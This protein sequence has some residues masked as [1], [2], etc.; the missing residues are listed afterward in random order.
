MRIKKIS[1][2]QQQIL[3]WWNDTSPYHDYNA[4]ICDGAVRSGKTLFM[5][6]SF[7]FWA[8]S[9]YTG[10]QFGICGKTINSLRRNVISVILPILRQFGFLCEERVSRG[11]LTI[12][13]GGRRNTFY[14]FG[15]RDEG[16]ASL[17]QGVTF[18]G[19]MLDEVA[20]MPRSFVEQACARCSIE[21]SKIWFNCNPDSPEHWFYKEWILKSEE[22]KTYHL[23]L[24]MADNPAL[25]EKIRARYETMY[26][27][28]FY[29]RFILGQW[30]VAEGRVYD[31]FDN[32]FVRSVPDERFESWYISCDY[33]TVNPASFGLWGLLNGVWY[34]INEFYFDSRK[35]GF[36][37]TDEE[38]GVK[39][40]ELAGDRKI[41]AVIV[42][43][44]AASFIEV[45]IRK[46]FSVIRAKNDVLAG[47]R[48]TSDLLK[49]GEIVI[50]DTCAD[51]IRE[52]SLYAWDDKARCDAVIK[53]NDHAMDEIRY[54]AYTIVRREDDSFTA[55]YVER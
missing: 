24:T 40:T 14:Y 22:R 25:S 21:G 47:I 3:T 12:S 9:R 6:L 28:V 15:G 35:C 29:K 2:K 4:I 23:H 44:S 53:Q 50:C 39:V 48:I 19:A 33:G 42:D 54:F 5:G 41:N 46:G 38:Y 20:L 36:Q 7:I 31:F 10:E 52:F 16:S 45:L 37:M 55:A 32:S 27:G 26:N 18:A 49:N 17:I 51:A 11:M 1:P 43:P 13:F 34:R 30:V 8:M